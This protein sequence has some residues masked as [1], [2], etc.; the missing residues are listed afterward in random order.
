M[1]TVRILFAAA[2][3]A[4][5]VSGPSVAGPVEDMAEYKAL[6][7]DFRAMLESEDPM[8]R[9]AAVEIGLQHE[10]AL[11]RK[12]AKDTAFASEDPVLQTRALAA[13]L[14]AGPVLAVRFAS[15]DKPDKTQEQI[16]KLYNQLVIHPENYDETLDQFENR[17][18]DSWHWGK[19]RVISRGFE[20]DLR[21]LRLDMAIASPNVLAGSGRMMSRS[22][23]VGDVVATIQLQ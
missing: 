2:A 5:A 11:I 15:P 20:C 13:Y 23:S 6:L 9:W 8:E 18:G 4:M 22:G 12:L 16:V 19:C 1:M 10:N 14:K 17:T 3:F 7:T 21:D